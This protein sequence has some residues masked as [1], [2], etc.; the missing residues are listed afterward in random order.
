MYGLIYFGCIFLIIIQYL[1][2]KVNSKQTYKTKLSQGDKITC[3]VL[4]HTIS[5]LK[6]C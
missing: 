4:E 2:V 1:K 6:S 5:L 3:V